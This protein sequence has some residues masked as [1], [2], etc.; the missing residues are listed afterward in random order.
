MVLACSAASAVPANDDASSPTLLI[1]DVPGAFDNTD[2]TAE[3]GE[4]SPG[5]GS[6]GPEGTCNQ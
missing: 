1:V 6:S 4:V 2:A 5:P 3:V